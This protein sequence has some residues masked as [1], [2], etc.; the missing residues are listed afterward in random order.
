MEIIF[1]PRQ[2]VPQMS[3]QG[4]IAPVAVFGI[5]SIAAFIAVW[6]MAKDD[7]RFY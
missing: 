3:P 6:K 5:V 2:E 4:E 1:T 7:R